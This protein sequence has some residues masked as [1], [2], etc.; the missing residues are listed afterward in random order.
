MKKLLYKLDYKI[1]ECFIGYGYGSLTIKGRVYSRQIRFL[2]WKKL[3]Y[4]FRIKETIY[5]I[6]MDIIDSFLNTLT[7]EQK[8]N[9]IEILS[10]DSIGGDINYFVY[11]IRSTM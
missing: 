7:V 10:G 1:D 4:E 3:S 9:L 11:R 5:Q 8:L 6:N 2:W